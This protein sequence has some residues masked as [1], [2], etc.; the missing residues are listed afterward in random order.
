MKEIKFKA[1][2]INDNWV[3]GQYVYGEK[4]KRHRIVDGNVYYK[5]NPKTIC[6]YIT[7]RNRIELYEGDLL[8]DR[9]PIDDLSDEMAE[10]L[11]PIIWVESNLQWCVDTSFK[12]DGSHYCSIIDF[13]GNHIEV[14]GNIQD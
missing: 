12:K 10:S 5:I 11:L 9:Y 7:T 2:D 3:S 13:F 1:K 14:K 4:Y 8:V 6:Q